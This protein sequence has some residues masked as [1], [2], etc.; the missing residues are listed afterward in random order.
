MNDLGRRRAVP[1]R[2]AD[3]RGSLPPWRSPSPSSAPP[4]LP[5]G[6]RPQREVAKGSHP[7]RARG[8]GNESTAERPRHQR[9]HLP[10]RNGPRPPTP[11]GAAPHPRLR[12]ASPPVPGRAPTRSAGLGEMRILA[13]LT[14]PGVVRPILR[15]LRIPEHPAPISPARAPPQTELLAVSTHP[16][17]GIRGVRGTTRRPATT[18]SIR[19][20]PE[21]TGPGAPETLSPLP[22]APRPP[23]ARLLRNVASGRRRVASSATR[24]AYPL[25]NSWPTTPRTHF[26]LSRGPHHAHG[27]HAGAGVLRSRDSGVGAT[28]LLYDGPRL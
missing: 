7:L 14:D 28:C 27:P 20:C 4:P 19:A 10:S 1:A 9:P 11:V 24:I 17:H 5:R 6:V 15:H 3:R 8:D 23:P 26:R 12:G 22:F 21:T 25:K 2:R 16:H 13:F 18:P